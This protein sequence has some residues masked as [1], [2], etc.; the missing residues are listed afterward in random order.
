MIISTRAQMVKIQRTGFK[1]C[2][3]D[4]LFKKVLDK[5]INI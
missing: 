1:G 4:L 5:I 2:N 3:P